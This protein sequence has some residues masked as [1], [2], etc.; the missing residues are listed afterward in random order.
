MLITFIKRSIID[1]Q[2]LAADN[3]LNSKLGALEKIQQDQETAQSLKLNINSKQE[4]FEAFLNEAETAQL[5]K[6]QRRVDELE[7]Q[8]GL[9]DKQGLKLIDEM[10]TSRDEYEKMLSLHKHKIAKLEEDL[11][12]LQGKDEEMR[13]I[14]SESDSASRTVRTWNEKKR[15]DEEHDE[16]ISKLINLMETA[17]EIGKLEHVTILEEVEAKEVKD[18]ELIKQQLSTYESAS[19]SST[20]SLRIARSDIELQLKSK[21]LELRENELPLLKRNNDE[22]VEKTNGVPK[23]EK[24]EKEMNAH[25]EF[26]AARGAADQS[27]WVLKKRLEFYY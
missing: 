6:F 12:L 18:L 13:N 21:D 3:N 8:N 16:Q 26:L 2:I 20:T 15:S 17:L 23:G 14:A 19:E 25:V 1:S 24:F 7:R 22:L 10:K 11:K 9:N 4:A 5:T 27:E